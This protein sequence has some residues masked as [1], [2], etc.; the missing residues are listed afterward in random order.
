VVDGLG[1]CI[2]ALS[3]MHFARIKS[4]DAVQGSYRSSMMRMQPHI[5]GR[6][7]D[8]LKVIEGTLISVFLKD[9]D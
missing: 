1:L 5:N 4:A 9:Q 6:P 2:V 3:C 7:G 8:C